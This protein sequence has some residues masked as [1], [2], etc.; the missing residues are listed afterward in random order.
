MAGTETVFV[1]DGAPD[2]KSGV[3]VIYVEVRGL[4]RVRWGDHLRWRGSANHQVVLPPLHHHLS[5]IES[6]P[7]LKEV[8]W[9]EMKK[10]YVRRLL[11]GSTAPICTYNEC[12]GCK[13]KCR[14]EQIPVDAND[15]I[16][17]A[18]HYRCVCHSWLN[19]LAVSMRLRGFDAQNF[20]FNSSLHQNYQDQ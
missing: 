3:V 19:I 2:R 5:T 15:P 8:T 6:S 4:L 11:I 7:T 17:S 18:Y 14:A 16:N 10:R 12:R 9:E 20:K 13:F 1:R